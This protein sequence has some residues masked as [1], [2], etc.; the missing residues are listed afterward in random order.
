MPIN[1]GAP[2]GAE[3]IA[4]PTEMGYQ[5]GRG[6]MQGTPASA[7][8][9]AP[10]TSQGYTPSYTGTQSDEPPGM[11]QPI[12]T[13]TIASPINTGTI[14]G[15]VSPKRATWE[16][17]HPEFQYPNTVP[18]GG[19]LTGQQSAE[20]SLAKARY[21]RE[22]PEN[23]DHG[24][25]GVLKEI[26]SNFFEGLKYAKPGMGLLQSLALGGAGA[27]AGAI[28]RNWN[29][30]RGLDK[31]IPQLEKDVEQETQQS[32]KNA[33]ITDTLA[34]P[35]DRE[36]ELRRKITK[37]EAVAEYQDNQIKL[38]T[39]KADELKIYRDAIVDLKERG[40]DQNDTRIKL[41][42][43]TIKER[44]RHNLETEKDADLNRD[45]RITVAN[46]LAGSREKVAGMQIGAQGERQKIAL[47]AQKE[48][49]AY[50][51]D[52][53]AGRAESADKRKKELMRL[54]A[55]YDAGGTQADTEGISASGSVEKP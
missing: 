4:V 49:A 14:S 32:L 36:R 42:E 26:L 3:A 28:N 19:Q 18:E 12:T 16:Q 21:Q 40:A 53:A 5:Y 52:V 48:L 50:N 29:E 55:L 41:L 43:D 13:D 6:E 9:I 47:A 15:T 11:T 38:G 44:G 23:L 37:D 8:R 39:K 31:L 46:I 1:W 25:K 30:Q 7:E 24:V 17:Q 22:H 33:Q 34:K 51:A 54:K 35:G 27:G 10:D 2:E 45:A 20:N